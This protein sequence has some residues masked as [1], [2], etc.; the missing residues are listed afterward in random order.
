M[1]LKMISKYYLAIIT[2]I[3]GC[4]LGSYSTL[5]DGKSGSK[6]IESE[7][8][9][10]DEITKIYLAETDPTPSEE[11]EN[12]ISQQRNVIAGASS[13]ETIFPT[14]DEAPLYSRH[15]LLNVDYEDPKA[16]WHNILFQSEFVEEKLSAIDELVQLQ[17]SDLLA[18]GLGDKSTEIRRVTIEGLVLIGDFNSVQVLGQ[19]LFYEKDQ[20]IYAHIVEALTT[21]AYHDNAQVFLD[22]LSNKETQEAHQ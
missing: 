7:L 8:D 19:A 2:F 5:G 11:P 22:Y 14:I 1:D 4:L 15:K 6:S 9:S 17:N 10:S 13:K 18:T 12:S 21:L 16:Y 20:I 3:I